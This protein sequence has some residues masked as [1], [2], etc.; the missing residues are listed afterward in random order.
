MQLG[1]SMLAAIAAMSDQ[2]LVSA[3]SS[4]SLIDNVHK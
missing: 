1:Q 3:F 4:I 2:T